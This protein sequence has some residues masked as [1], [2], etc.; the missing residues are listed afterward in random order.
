MPSVADALREGLGAAMPAEVDGNV[1]GGRFLRPG[2]GYR[3]AVSATRLLVTAG[4]ARWSLLARL[5][6]FN[7]GATAPQ[8]ITPQLPSCRVERLREGAARLGGEPRIVFLR[9][10]ECRR[11]S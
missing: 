7:R 5:R 10:E 2:C 8:R 6:V 11:K 3:K 1:P 9:N 4:P